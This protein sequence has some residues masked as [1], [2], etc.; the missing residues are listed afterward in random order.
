[1]LASVYQTNK[2]IFDSDSMA[3]SIIWHMTYKIQYAP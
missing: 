2:K 1:M 3:L